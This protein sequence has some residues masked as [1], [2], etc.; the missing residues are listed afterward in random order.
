MKR[1]AAKRRRRARLPEVDETL[2]IE[3]L[4]LTPTERLEKHR[5]YIALVEELQRAAGLRPNLQ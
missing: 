4:R 5:A 3:S 2:I 1:P